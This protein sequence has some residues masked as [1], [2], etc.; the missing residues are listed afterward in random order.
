MRIIFMALIL[1]FAVSFCYG[2]RDISA[3]NP[4]GI[5]PQKRPSVQG[6]E[7]L[8]LSEKIRAALE[9]GQKLEALRQLHEEIQT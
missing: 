7:I 3:R 2:T 4:T 5:D 8:P 6:I 1:V 9:D